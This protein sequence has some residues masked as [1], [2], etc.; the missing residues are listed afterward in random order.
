MSGFW[1]CYDRHLC[2]IAPLEDLRHVK[3]VKKKILPD[4]GIPLLVFLALWCT[5]HNIMRFWLQAYW[6]GET[7]LT[8]ILCLAPEHHDHLNNM[9]PDVQKLVDPYELSPFIT[10]VGF[11]SLFS[12]QFSSR[13]LYILIP[14]QRFLSSHSI[15]FSVESHIFMQ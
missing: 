1:L 3:R 9:P 5:K 6:T 11:F 12:P 13:I 2:K 8:V 14:S 15:I 4:R 7:Q 10:Q